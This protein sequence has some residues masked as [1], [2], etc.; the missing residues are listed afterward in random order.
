MYANITFRPVSQVLHMKILLVLPTF[1]LI[2]PEIILI[3][4]SNFMHMYL[5]HV[6]MHLNYF[7]TV[8]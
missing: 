7:G 3:E 5:C 2:T 8:M 4:T 1:M 6:H